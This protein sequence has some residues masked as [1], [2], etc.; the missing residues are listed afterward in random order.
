HFNVEERFLFPILGKNNRLIKEAL[1]QH[2]N[3]QDLFK[4]TENLE[5]VLKRIE[6]ELKQHIRFEERVLFNTIQNAASLEQ[7]KGLSR[8]DT[9]ARFIENTKDE[10][11]L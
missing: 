2:K 7:L 8:F 11:W 10:F 3:L 5:L 6:K 4:K 1:A 9:E